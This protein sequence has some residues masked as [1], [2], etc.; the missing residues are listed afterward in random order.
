MKRDR[1]WLPLHFAV[2]SPDTD[3]DEDIGT[4]LISQPQAIKLMKIDDVYEFNSFHLAVIVVEDPSGVEVIQLLQANCAFVGLPLVEK[5]NTALDLAVMHSNS[6][7]VV[8][9]LIQSY[10]PALEMRNNEDQTPLCMIYKNSTSAALRIL[11]VLLDAAPHVAQIVNNLKLELLPLNE[12][13]FQYRSK[14]YH[15]EQPKIIAVL[16]AAYCGAVNRYHISIHFA[17]GIDV[18]VLKKVIDEANLNNLSSAVIDSVVD[19]AIKWRKLDI[20]RYIHFR[21]PELLTA[22]NSRNRYSLQILFFGDGAGGMTITM[23]MM[24]MIM[25]MMMMMMMMMM[26]IMM[27]MMMMMM[28]VLTIIES[29]PHYSG[30]C[31]RTR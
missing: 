22:P 1:T 6:V 5:S 8:Q 28:M 11:H 27:M 15:H 24:I 19:V 21:M 10:F 9:E 13:V 2:N 20:L 14:R 26:M 31:I 29:A 16:V 18:R 23:I 30:R 3:L 7:A 12:I 25:I 17:A 4:I